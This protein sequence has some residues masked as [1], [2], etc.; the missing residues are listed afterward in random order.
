M[1]E[2]DNTQVKS[3]KTIIDLLK[4]KDAAVDNT[5]QLLEYARWAEG[6][7][8]FDD[9]CAIMKQIVDLKPDANDQGLKTLEV[10][11]RQMLSVA[12]KNV[13]GK[14]RTA[15]RSLQVGEENNGNIKQDDKKMQWAKPYMDQYKQLLESETRARCQEVLDILENH[16]IDQNARLYYVNS[17]KAAEL[18]HPYESGSDKVVKS[19][20]NKDRVQWVLD[21]WYKDVIEKDSYTDEWKKHAVWVDADGKKP[22]IK[23]L[24]DFVESSNG[25]KK[26]TTKPAA[27]RHRYNTVENLVFYLKMCGDY[28]RYLAEFNKPRKEQKDG[29]GK[30]IKDEA[31]KS[32][33]LYDDA[34]ACANNCLAPTN[35]TRL[36]LSLNMSV[37]HYEI[38]KDQ[39]KACKLAKEAFDF[40]IAK[41]DSLNDHNY[42]DSTLIMQLLR[43][44]LTIWT[45]E[46]AK[47]EEED[48]Q[49]GTED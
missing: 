33:D 42:K 17:W 39:S 20:K 27:I 14:R 13:V 12:F 19:Q 46:D 44:N 47:K 37:C 9:M 26:G 40:A 3:E 24:K 49:K 22:V 6:A 4:E 38:L 28:Y 45:N 5:S 48:K 1:A 31:D 11:E 10:E 35:P 32:A 41:L 36:G 21:E 30:K 7:E 34:L 43:D 18:Q 2:A 15:L 25:D 23:E 16:L 29:D 8:R